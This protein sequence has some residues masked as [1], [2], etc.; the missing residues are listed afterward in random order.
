MIFLIST[1]VT[2]FAVT[3]RSEMPSN[4]FD[5]N[6]IDYNLDYW[7]MLTYIF[8]V[9]MEMCNTVNLYF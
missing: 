8:F 2:T 5:I 1:K 7:Y 3:E 4:Y 6:V 9:M